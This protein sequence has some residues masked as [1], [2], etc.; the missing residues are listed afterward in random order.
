LLGG[1][2][3]YVVLRSGTI[4]TGMLLHFLNN[5]AAL[6][7][8][9]DLFPKAWRDILHLETLQDTGLPIWLLVTAVLVFTAGIV[10][11][12]RGSNGKKVQ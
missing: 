11:M 2:L 7:L 6:L 4:Y 9:S 5:A 1:V 10:V 8:S 3:T 12:E